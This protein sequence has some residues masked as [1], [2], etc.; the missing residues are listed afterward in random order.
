[1]KLLLAVL[2]LGMM[3]CG[4]DPFMPKLNDDLKQINHN[5]DV[6]NRLMD[7]TT[8]GNRCIEA[9]IG[10]TSAIL[11]EN[12][13]LM[14]STKKHEDEVCGGS[15]RARYALQDWLAV[16]SPKDQIETDKFCRERFPR[17]TP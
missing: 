5:L 16:N 9:I 4:P 17:S 8:S 2:L 1:M 10:S 14:R 13:S 3:G 7:L 12:R 6:A 15:C 11:G